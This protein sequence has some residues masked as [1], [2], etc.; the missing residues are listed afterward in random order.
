MGIKI[1]E[2][3]LGTANVNAVVPA[4]NADGNV[5]EKIKLGDI[6]GLYEDWNV[7][8]FS[9][10]SFTA[11]AGKKYYY[12]PTDVML[13]GLDIND[14]S[15]PSNGDYYFFWNMSAQEIRVGGVSVPQGQIVVRYFTAGAISGV[16]TTQTTAAAGSFD[17]S[18][19]SLSDVP[20][21]FTPSAHAASHLFDGDGNPG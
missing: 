21:S 19:N 20:S 7:P 3:P 16:W 1:S 11:S 10:G 13:D 6:A 14:P 17:G 2:L 8:T 9:E 15:S 18:Y 12:K 4:T 5:T